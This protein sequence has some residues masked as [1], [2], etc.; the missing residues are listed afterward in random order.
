[1][2]QELADNGMEINEVDKAPFIKATQVVYENYQDQY[3]ELIARIQ[4]EA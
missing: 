2:K 4:A 3:G 1:M